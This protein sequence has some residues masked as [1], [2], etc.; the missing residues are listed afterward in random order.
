M[1]ASHGAPAALRLIWAILGPRGVG[2][3]IFMIFSGQSLE[4]SA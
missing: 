1:T 4:K 2:E 3:A